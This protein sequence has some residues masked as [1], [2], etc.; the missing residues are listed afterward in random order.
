MTGLD[1]ALATVAAA[2]V[3]L[4]CHEA[5]HRLRRRAAARRCDAARWPHPRTTPEPRRVVV[6][7]PARWWDTTDEGD[8]A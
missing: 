5:A 7:G 8:A 1:L 3:W 4:L 2:V 6:H